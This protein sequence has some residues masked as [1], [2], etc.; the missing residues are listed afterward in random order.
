MIRLRC[1]RCATT[2]R[3][4]VRSLGTLAEP[5]GYPDTAIVCGTAGCNEPACV[6]LWGC[7]A[8]E[9][10]NGGRLVFPLSNNRLGKVRVKPPE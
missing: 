3:L 4:Q 9:Y 1:V 8:I 7:D 10:R 6:W 5:V 2:R